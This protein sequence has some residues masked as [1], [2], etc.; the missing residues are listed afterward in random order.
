M[1]VPDWGTNLQLLENTHEMLVLILESLLVCK[2]VLHV[3]SSSLALAL[4][5]VV[6]VFQHLHLLLKLRQLLLLALPAASSRLPV[7]EHPASQH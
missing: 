2:D 1:S 4:Q 3:H 5:V 7:A 6:L